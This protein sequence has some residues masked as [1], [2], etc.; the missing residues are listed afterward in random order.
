MSKGTE[1]PTIK[2]PNG[3][4]ECFE[5]QNKVVLDYNP[6]YKVVSMSPYDIRKGS[7]N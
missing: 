6:K 3:K 2:S 7:N 1:G 5:Q 4:A